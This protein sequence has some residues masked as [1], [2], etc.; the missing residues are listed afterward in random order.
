LVQAQPDSVVA[1][2]AGVAL[3]VEATAL[4]TSLKTAEGV[5][6]AVRQAPWTIIDPA[7]HLT[8]EG[9]R[10]DAARLR[11]DVLQALKADE[12]VTALK[13][14]L[15]GAQAAAAALLA[16]V[17]TP[18]PRPGPTPVPD[19]EPVKPGVKRMKQAG[20]AP[21]KA[22]ELL[23]RLRDRGDVSVTVEWTEPE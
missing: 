21:A 15:E 9:R 14:A 13:P 3:D 10:D 12:Y 20:L 17:V 11:E 4:G 8:D 16:R 2:L 7:M 5:A 1:K 19:P 23:D 18:P 6:S 22:R